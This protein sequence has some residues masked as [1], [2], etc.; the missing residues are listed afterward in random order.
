M[1]T[2][3]VMRSVDKPGQQTTI[4]YQDVAFDVPIGAENFSLSSLKR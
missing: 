3:L 1:P 2:R 4:V